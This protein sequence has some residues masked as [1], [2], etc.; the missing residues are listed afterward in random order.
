L[1][2]QPGGNLTRQA[3][4]DATIAETLDKQA[5]IG[6]PLPLKPVTASSKASLT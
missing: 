1:G 3:R 6:G 4:G 5:D 2:C